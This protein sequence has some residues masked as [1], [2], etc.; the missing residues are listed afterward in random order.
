MIPG[1]NPD[2]GMMC[3]TNVY[4]VG[5]GKHFYMIDAC[6]KD[7]QRFLENVEKFTTDLDCQFDGILITHAHHDHMDGALNV[8]ELMTKLGRPVPKVYKYIDGNEPEK[9]RFKSNPGL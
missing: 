7:H 4:A 2:Y 8:I 9:D 5:K 3:G 6:V 1:E